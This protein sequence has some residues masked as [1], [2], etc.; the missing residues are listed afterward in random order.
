MVEMRHCARKALLGLLGLLGYPQAA[1]NGSLSLWDQLTDYV[2]AQ[3]REGEKDILGS[4]EPEVKAQL[5]AAPQMLRT[6]GTIIILTNHLHNTNKTTSSNF[7][8][9]L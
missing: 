8:I 3:H 4:F 1:G 7:C 6:E 2:P 5:V 9:S